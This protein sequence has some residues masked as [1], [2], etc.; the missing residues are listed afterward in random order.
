MSR[1][2][3]P[4]AID[5]EPNVSTDEV[6]NVWIHHNTIEGGGSKGIQ[7]W[8][9]MAHARFGEI[10]I[11]DNTIRGPR[12][13]GIWCGGSSVVQEGPVTIRRNTITGAA[14]PV[15]IENMTVDWDGAPRKKRKKRKKKLRGPL[16]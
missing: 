4:G 16:A 1:I 11:E 12:D 6:W 10:L 8:N 7:L 9:G 15:L 3:M 5:L 13:V 2:D 14:T